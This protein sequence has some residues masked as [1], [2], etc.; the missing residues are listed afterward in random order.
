IMD[1][2]I[3]C[4][5][6]ILPLKELGISSIKVLVED[7]LLAELLQLCLERQGF[8]DVMFCNN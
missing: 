2:I 8:S 4:L 3:Y 7:H 6:R 5:N 1:M